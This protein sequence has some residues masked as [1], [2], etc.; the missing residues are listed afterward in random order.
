MAVV[1]RA[2]SHL[3]PKVMDMKLARFGR[4]DETRR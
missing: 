1:V 2:F 4:G 3:R